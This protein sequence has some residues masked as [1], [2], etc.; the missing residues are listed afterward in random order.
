MNM[1]YFVVI[2][3]ARPLEQVDQVFESKKLKR[4]ECGRRIVR[5]RNNDGRSMQVFADVRTT[6]SLEAILSC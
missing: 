3:V 6:S 1:C 4:I 5:S 2:L